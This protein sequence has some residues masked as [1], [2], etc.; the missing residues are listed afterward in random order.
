MLLKHTTVISCP[1]SSPGN[2]T[3]GQGL[4]L[5]EG[6]NTLGLWQWQVEVQIPAMILT[7]G[8]ISNESLNVGIFYLVP[9][10]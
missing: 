5:L 9:G 4:E 2:Q 3:L 6:W 8:M 7:S 10:K 1:Y